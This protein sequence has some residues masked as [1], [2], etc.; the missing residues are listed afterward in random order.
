[1][2]II[3]PLQEIECSDFRE[4]CDYF[5][6]NTNKIAGDNGTDEELIIEEIEKITNQKW[7]LNFI[8]TKYDGYFRLQLIEE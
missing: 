8:N 4:F 6:I 5:N 2:T 1:M 3:K 7:I